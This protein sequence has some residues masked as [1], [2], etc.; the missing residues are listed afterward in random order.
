MWP[1]VLLCGGL[2]KR[3][4]PL[5]EMLPKSLLPIGD[6]P[7]IL[8][9]L[10]LLKSRGITEVILCAG[11]LGEQIEAVVGNGS[12]FGM[13]VTY[14]Y[15]GDKLLG[16]GGAIIKAL[17]L[18]PEKFFIMYGD[19]YLTCDFAAVARS[20]EVS[21]QKSLMTVYNNQDRW[22][23]SNVEFSDNTI[24]VYDKINKTPAMHYIDYGLGCFKRDVFNS[25]PE[26]T[27]IDLAAIYADLVSAKQLA[28]FEVKE[29]FYEIGSFDG[30]REFEALLSSE[31]Y[32]LHEE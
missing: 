5:T 31:Q 16:T 7:F 27:V 29:R 30:M 9:Q 24:Q 4:R 25:Y 13:S 14:S 32:V 10:R 12:Q 3:M 23:S 18:L 2:A 20:F 15:E 21:Q 22:D 1:V 11:F 28:G 19:S 8:H 6:E 26:N 17:A